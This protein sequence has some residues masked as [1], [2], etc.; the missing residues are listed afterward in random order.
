MKVLSILKPSLVF[1]VVFPFEE[2]HYYASIHAELNN[3][4]FIIC[5][6]FCIPTPVHI[7]LADFAACM[8]NRIIPLS[9][10]FEGLSF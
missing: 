8:S 3:V 1:A 7:V 2:V 5:I 4:E 6:S 9:Y 10:I